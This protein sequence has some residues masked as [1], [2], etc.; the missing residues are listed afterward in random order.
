MSHLPGKFVW[1]EHSS[2]DP[3]QARAFYTALLGWSVQSM[4]IGSEAYDMIML[5]AEGIGGMRKAEAGTPSHWMSYLSV[6]DV[7]A[8]FKAATTNGASS[9][10]A[11][12][13][14]G[15]VGRAAIIADPTGATVSLWKGAQGDRPDVEKMPNGDWMWNELWTPDAAKALA[16]YETTFGFTHDSMDMGPQGTYYILKGQDGKMRGG[17]MQSTGNEAPPMWL[18][19]VKVADCDASAAKAQKLGARAIVVPPTDIPNI[20]RFSVLLDP[21]G[22]AIAVMKPAM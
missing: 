20:G 15:P 16:F 12:M 2:P 19:Y 5:G 4:P 21:F 13:D 9:C 1:F 6:P 17:L 22:A 18:P 11:P 8:S 7:D 10:L 3:A 14:F